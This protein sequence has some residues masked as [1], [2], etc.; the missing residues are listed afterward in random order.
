M[1]SCAI[2][3]LSLSSFPSER[4]A[5]MALSKRTRFEVFKRDDFTCQYC[6]KRAPEVV[7][8][9][10]HI[11]AR[12]NGGSDDAIN[13]RTA[14]VDCN[15]G[16]SAVPLKESQLPDYAT[17]AERLAAAV[18]YE[19]LQDDLR[20]IEDAQVD[21]MIAHFRSW[22]KYP[23]T[24][25]YPKS[26]RGWIRRHGVSELRDAIDIACDRMDDQENACRYLG[27][28]MRNKKAQAE[29]PLAVETKPPKLVWSAEERPYA[30][31]FGVAEDEFSDIDAEDGEWSDLE[32]ERRAW[33]A[34]E[35]AE[36]EAA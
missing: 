27:G 33:D 5:Q 16:K 8:H 17:E 19:R 10:D 4:Q 35:R 36:W 32:I 11:V 14:C 6:G 26:V 24:A 9:V 1:P 25:P 15:L 28:I 21:E 29:K 7:L 2:D 20:A 34:V 18:A 23:Q 30:Y 31:N 22:W 13:L 3:S 12:A